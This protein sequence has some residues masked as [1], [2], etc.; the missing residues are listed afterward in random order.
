MDYCP[1]DAIK[2]ANQRVYIA[3]DECV[4]CGV[5]KRSGVCP[6]DALVQPE[7]EWPRLVRSEFSN[8]VTA[9]SSTNLGG[10]GTA[11]M[12]TNDVTG[13]FKEGQA[14]VALEI[15]RPGVGTRVWEVEKIYKE[16][17]KFGAEFEKNNPVKA[18]V[19]DQ[20]K[21]NFKK[22][23]LD[24]RVLS[25]IIEF[26]VPT[27]NLPDLLKLI[28]KISEETTTVFSV[29]LV[30]KASVDGRLENYEIAKKLGYNVSLNGK[31]NVGLGKP[32]S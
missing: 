10:R 13:R 25:A 23:L 5:C 18:L 32:R 8:P 6:V 12:K 21:G 22:E 19:A 15:G 29:C 9:H 27:A 31:F 2:L 30:S 20:E 14:G 17:V 26:N 1:V 3:E 11:E 24:Q 7:L 28:E 4:E 16:I